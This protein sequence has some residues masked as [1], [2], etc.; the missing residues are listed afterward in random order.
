MFHGFEWSYKHLKHV[1]EFQA[2]KSL[3]HD[4]WLEF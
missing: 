1:A 3:K 4:F 2:V